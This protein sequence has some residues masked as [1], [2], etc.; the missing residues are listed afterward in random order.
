MYSVLS[1]TDN[2]NRD[3]G[4]LHSLEAF[5]YNKK[6]GY[7]RESAAV[8]YHSLVTALG[9]SSLPLLLPS[10]P[11]L[12]ELLSDKGDVVRTG[13][14]SAIRALIS[15]TPVQAIPS[16]IDILAS[17]LVSNGK[18][19]AKVGCLKEIARLTDLRGD[20]G[21]EEVAQI[22][23]TLLP[24]IEKSMH[25]TKAEVAT[26]AKKTAT[27]LCGTLPNPDLRP[28][29]PLLISAMAA[30]NTVPETIKSLSNT[31]F[32]AEVTSPSLAVLVPLLSRG[33]NDRGMDTQRRTV[34]VVE[35][36]CKLVRDPAV[37]AR[38]LSPLVHGV[39][40]IATGASFPEVR[41]FASSTLKTLLGSGATRLSDPDAKAPENLRDIP[42]ETQVA[43]TSMSPLLPEY[44]FVPS[45]NTPSAP[46]TPFHPSFK[47]SIQ[48]SGRL[49]ADLIAKKS[50]Q[51]PKIWHTC[52]GVYL[53]PW[54]V[55]DTGTQEEE[56]QKVS[57]SVRNKFF[58]I[59]KVDYSIAFLQYITNTACF[60]SRL[61]QPPSTKETRTLS[62]THCSLW[63][64][65][66]SYFSLIQ[67][68][69]LFEG[70][71]T[72][73][74]LGTVVARVLFY[75]RSRT[76]KWKDSLLKTRSGL[77]WSST[78]CKAKMGA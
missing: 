2:W 38:Y 19:K 53:A 52:V 3:G 77:S 69:D 49:V 36:V 33:L 26:Q 42:A 45:P 55:P 12:L 24:I 62:A 61:G 48:F 15:L 16:V 39:D 14:N 60:I 20:A 51:D 40:A 78:H 72:E 68:S 44:L 32:V 22:L 5:A 1:F 7:E 13:A 70:V 46:P 25:D 8:G 9:P 76:A 34:V 10:L 18:W 56:A 74:A 59:E 21:R 6:S 30:P 47:Q 54:L 65:V 63:P 11:V 73:S 17:E 58:D 75:V 66:L 50:F 37:A 57:E 41:E 35:N 43:I 27:T 67:L 64:T 28:H 4:V 29:I 71:A 23:G 31:T